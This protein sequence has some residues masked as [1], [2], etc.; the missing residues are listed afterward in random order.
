MTLGG[1]LQR[2]CNGK[3]CSCTYRRGEL[4][5][6]IS[7]WF[8]DGDFILTWEVCRED[9]QNNENAYTRD[10]PRL[11]ESAEELLA[12]VEQQRFPASVCSVHKA[13]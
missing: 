5:G 9:D 6:L 10:D 7:A 4:A 11:F 12:F 8:H 3:G 2:M 13:N 1:F